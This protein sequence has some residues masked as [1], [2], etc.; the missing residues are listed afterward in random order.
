MLVNGTLEEME[1]QIIDQLY[2]Q[3]QADKKELARRL[4]I[5]RTT[6]W[7]IKQLNKSDDG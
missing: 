7:K 6:L 3:N 5:S 1:R 4:G 2:R